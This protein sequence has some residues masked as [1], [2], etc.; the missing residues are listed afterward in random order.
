[1]CALCCQKRSDGESSMWVHHPC[2]LG[3]PI[4]GRNQ[5][6]YKVPMVGRVQYGGW[7]MGKN[8]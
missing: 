4:V 8:G 5:Y 2:L 1:M 3:V 7:N 6:G